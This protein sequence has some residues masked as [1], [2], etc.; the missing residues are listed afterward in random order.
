MS[1]QPHTV[2][3]MCT[4][5]TGEVSVEHHALLSHH[6]ETGRATQN[7]FNGTEKEHFLL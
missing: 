3:T 7:H 2:T 6:R 4:L 1:V 5:Y